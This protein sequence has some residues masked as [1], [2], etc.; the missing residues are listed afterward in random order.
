MPSTVRFLS[1]PIVTAINFHTSGRINPPHYPRVY[2]TSEGEVQFAPCHV[3]LHKTKEVLRGMTTGLLRDLHPGMFKV[4]RATWETLKKDE[5]KHARTRA[6]RRLA[7]LRQWHLCMEPNDVQPPRQDSEVARCLA[8][9]EL[10]LCTCALLHAYRQVL[11]TAK[12]FFFKD[13]SSLFRDSAGTLCETKACVLASRSTHV[14]AEIFSMRGDQH[15]YFQLI[16][17]HFEAMCRDACA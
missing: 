17:G 6:E 10:L 8:I 1:S 3:T 11:N 2:H 5:L 9:V 13:G 12:P 15:H 16:L 7:A 14:Y 4:K